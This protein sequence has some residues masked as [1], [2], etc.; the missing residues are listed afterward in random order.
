MVM[1]N[2]WHE[3][4]YSKYLSW[5][6][7]RLNLS[8]SQQCACPYSRLTL[9]VIV[10]FF[11]KKNLFKL[12]RNSDKCAAVQF[13]SYS[14]YQSLV[15]NSVNMKHKQRQPRYV[16]NDIADTFVLIRMPTKRHSWVK[17][18]FVGVILILRSTVLTLNACFVWNWNN[19]WQKF[20]AL[21]TELIDSSVDIS[22]VEYRAWLKFY[23][24]W[25]LK[26]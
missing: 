5:R 16:F 20:I 6:F 8:V 25:F 18:L 15:L 24:K 1:V 2:T 9:Q 19:A 17:S 23:F 4:W 10:N 14:Q 13:A 21:K 11:R 3:I 7:L 22:I 26:L 12:T